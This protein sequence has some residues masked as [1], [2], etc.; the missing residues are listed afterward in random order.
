MVL[1]LYITIQKNAIVFH[2]D[3]GRLTSVKAC[4]IA[5]DG[6]FGVNVYLIMGSGLL[7]YILGS[8]SMTRLIGRLFAP[9]E[10]FSRHEYKGLTGDT[11]LFDIASATN[12][13]HKLG[14]KFGCL[15][16]ILDMLKVFLPT[17]FFRLALPESPY[18]MITAAMGVVGHNYP[19]FHKFKGGAGL[20]AAMGGLLVV[21]W[22]SVIVT[23][24]AGMILGLGLGRDAYIAST[25]WLFL[26]VPWFWI[27]THDWAH[28]IYVAVIL[29]SFLLATIP[30]TKQYIK[31][32]KKGPEALLA[33]Y[34]Q[35]PMGR[36]LVKIGRLFGLYKN[37]G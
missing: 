27:R 17:L 25:L 30:V 21:D 3:L 33:F 36:G 34:L 15:V 23:P 5:A 37:K 10:D 8:V 7:G 28:I 32:R 31:L 14:A 24:V 19:V 18:F 2:H 6:G 22:M 12:V 9:G 13:S 4:A 11:V 16:S 1:I 35:V 29:A 26:L 20:S